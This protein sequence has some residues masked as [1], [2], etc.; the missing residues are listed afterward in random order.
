M[1]LDQ[2]VAVDPYKSNRSTGAFIVIDRLSNITVGAGMVIAAN[3]ASV[4]LDNNFSEFELELHSL[5]KKH[6]ATEDVNAL[7][8]MLV[9]T[10][11]KEI[12]AKK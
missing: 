2:A 4:G 5:I 10:L 11:S 12:T 6:F 9:E 1:Q 3:E 7:S 8:A